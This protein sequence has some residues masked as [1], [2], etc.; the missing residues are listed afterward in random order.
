M[1]TTFTKVQLRRGLAAEWTQ[2]NTILE[3]G[4]IGFES[5]TYR[6]KIG[7]YLPNTKTLASW[8]EL[9][10][11]GR[12]LLEGEINID[13]QINLSTSTCFNAN[14]LPCADDAYTIGEAARR[15]RRVHASQAIQLGDLV[16]TQ[17]PAS[18]ATGEE[19]NF[20]KVNGDDIATRTELEKVT[21]KNLNLEN[22]AEDVSP[23]LIELFEILEMELPPR[24]GITT[25][26]QFNA[27]VVEALNHVDEVAHKGE[28][29]DEGN[30]IIGGEGINII[31]GPPPA[32]G[33]EP[34]CE[35]TLDIYS[36]TNVHCTLEAKKGIKVLESRATAFVKAN[37]TISD[38]LPLEQSNWTNVTRL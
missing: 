26:S 13:G 29:D 37:G 30:V 9:D 7:Q 4:E 18:E 35:T 3:V 12:E 2:Y 24:E 17:G 20:L 5:D 32:E 21:S 38:D 28:R 19:Q 1:S 14:I 10:Y 22:P 34:G 31:I 8:N 33:E 23:Y 11:F 6:F 25:Q 27:W 36:H 16:I 15:W